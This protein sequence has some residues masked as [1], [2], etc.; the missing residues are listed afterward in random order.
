MCRSWFRPSEI[1]GLQFELTQLTANADTTEE[2]VQPAAVLQTRLSMA[3][4]NVDTLMKADAER[5][6]EVLRLKDRVAT[7]Q[8]EVDSQ[9]LRASQAEVQA[10]DFRSRLIRSQACMGRLNTEL[11]R[12]KKELVSQGT[13][14]E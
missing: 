8:R 4:E 13:R 12:V 5:T 10:S 6:R 1:I 14:K 3:R 2:E 7:L 11:Q 9:Q